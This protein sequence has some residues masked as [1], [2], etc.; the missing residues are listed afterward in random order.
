MYN[1]YMLYNL[2]NVYEENYILLRLCVYVYGLVGGKLDEK[3]AYKIMYKY[4]IGIY[5]L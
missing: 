2:Y 4:L 3:K 1:V 5:R